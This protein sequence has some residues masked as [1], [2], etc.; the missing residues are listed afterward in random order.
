M[1]R[2][3]K[4]SE[5]DES[6]EGKEVELSGWV[7]S[8]RI[9]KSVVF[10]VLRDRYGKVQSV[11]SSKKEGFE[12]SKKLTQESCIYIKGIVKLRPEGQEN[13]EMGN[14]SKVEIEVNKLKIFNLCPPL[15]FDIK[16]KNTDEETRL[17]HRFLDLRTE[18]M[19]KNIILRGEIIKSTIEFFDKEGFTYFE[20][21][22][23]GKSTPEGARDFVV[24][25]RNHKG[26]FYALPQSPQLFK[27]LSQ[28]SGFDKYLQIARCFR[29][30]DTRKDRQPEFTQ[31]DVEMSFIEQEDIIELIER[32]MKHLFKEVLNIE[33]K[34]P[35]KRIS[36]DEAM[37]KY[38][39]DDPDLRENPENKDEFA[40][41]WVVD[42]PAFEYSEEDKRYKSTHHPFTMPVSGEKGK[43]D[44]NENSKSHA[45]D[46]VLNGSE[47][48]GGSLRIYDSEI[49]EKIFDILNLSRKEARE[50]F[51]FL[52]DALKYG[53]PPHGG[54]ALGMDRLVQ[55]MAREDTIR[56]V[57]PFPK[58]KEARD[59][60]LNAPS[61][62]SKDQ[63]DEAGINLN[64][65]KE[66]T[67]S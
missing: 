42:F 2:S 56:D 58:N 22:I 57:I 36:Y 62:I 63:L 20:T 28:V 47:I 26:K 23:L 46:L 61:E 50:K 4:I 53:S 11:I 27:Q 35:F 19:Q 43:L 7:E 29:D 8:I 41:C 25:S 51:G 16:N 31:I 12:N 39:R 59:L 34:I 10:I 18:R 60:M 55:L 9:L 13:P 38:G 24:P 37:E 6:Q 40:F 33:I 15:P 17:K 5:I 3:H 66:R 52:M 65:N 64:K 30:E 67:N 32:L 48:G 44:F 54:I 49:Q 21:P 1:L 14:S 45:Y